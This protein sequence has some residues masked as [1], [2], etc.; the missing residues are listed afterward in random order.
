MTK[1]SKSITFEPHG[2]SKKGVRA[3][4][5]TAGSVG[6]VL[7]SILPFLAK[8]GNRGVIKGGAT[9]GKWAPPVRY[10]KEVLVPLVF[11]KEPFLKVVKQGFYPEGGGLTVFSA[12]KT[13]KRVEILEKGDIEKV[14]GVSVASEELKEVEKRQADAARD[15]LQEKFSVSPE[16]RSETVNSKAVGSGIT[17]W[18][19]TEKSIFGGDCVGEKGKAAEKVGKEAAEELL[20]SYER[21]A[22]DQHASD[23][24]V[25]FIAINGGRIRVPEVTSHCETNVWVCN[26]FLDN[27]VKIDGR[28]IYCEGNEL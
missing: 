7:Q 22:V 10:V 18:M 24:L 14:K 4:I 19:E 28:Q 21:G 15:L 17:L 12:D 6:L 26:Q 13:S 8:R 11:E 1:G 20:E 23:Q 9:Y 16:I 5:E 3:E 2:T 25:P 27:E